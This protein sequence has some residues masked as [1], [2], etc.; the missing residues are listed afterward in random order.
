MNTRKPDV[1]NVDE[2]R[3]KLGHGQRHGPS[4]Q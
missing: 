3:E 2:A 1:A 4:G